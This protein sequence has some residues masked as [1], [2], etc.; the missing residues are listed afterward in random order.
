MNKRTFFFQFF[1]EIYHIL[2]C[3]IMPILVSDEEAIKKY[4]RKESK[5][6]LEVNLNNPKRFSEK[7]QW[8]KLNSRRPL[9][10]RCADKYAVRD[11]LKEIGCDYLLND[12][13][14]VYDKVSQI[15][16]DELPDSFVLKA[17]HGSGQNIIV[18]NKNNINWLKAK[19]MMWMWMHQHI[20]WSGR[21]WVYEKMPRHIVAE[22]Y[23]QDDSGGLKDYK[24]FCFNGK[25]RFMQLE[26]GRFT[27]YN[28]RNFYDMN[29]HLLPFG[30]E[31]CHNPDVTVEVPDK[32][33]EMK[34]IAERLAKP[35]QFVRIDLY[36]VKNKIFFGEFT[37][38]PAGG[39]PDF[40]PD[41]Y[42]A[43]VGDMWRLE[44]D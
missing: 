36:E 31:I 40:V 16:I 17:S 35:F 43:I 20:A 37:F 26:V 7:L 28:T 22:K 38:F 19:V 24:F 44:K 21:E 33:E 11:Y 2:K 6:K 15:N 30:K 32:F 1:I 27:K 8:Y 39:A 9:M 25:P 42:D 29:W 4:Y 12:I 10:Q 5:G 41:E 14:H 3:K 34:T 23:L 18:K 13:I